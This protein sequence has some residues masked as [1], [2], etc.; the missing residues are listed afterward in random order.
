MAQGTLLVSS[1]RLSP[2]LLCAVGLYFLGSLAL[3]LLSGLGQLMG[4]R[5]RLE[6]GPPLPSLPVATLDMSGSLCLPSACSESSGICP[7]KA[8]TLAQSP[9]AADRLWQGPLS[10][11]ILTSHLTC[12]C[13]SSSQ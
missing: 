4:A 13:V 1:A 6:N 8:G 9:V 12:Q 11:H 7:T 10:V 2:A 5:E 3:S